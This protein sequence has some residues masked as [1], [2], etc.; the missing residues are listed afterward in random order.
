ME[1]ASNIT[2]EN[3]IV[4]S[5]NC[6]G[7]NQSHPFLDDICKA[8]NAKIIMVQE[9]WQTPSNMSKIL[10]Y[11]SK[12][13]GFGVSAMDTALS[14]SVLRGRTYGGV[15]TLVR[16]DYLSYTTCLK[17]A[18]RYT[19]VSIGQTIFINVYFPCSSSSSHE[20]VETLLI[21]INDVVT[22]FPDFEIVMGGDFNCVLSDNSKTSNVIRRFMMKLNLSLVTDLIRPNCDYTYYHESLHHYSFVDYFMFTSSLTTNAIEFKVLDDML[23][24]SD[25]CGIYLALSLSMKTVDPAAD[26]GPKSA[27]NATQR[28]NRYTLRWDHGSLAD[29]YSIC[30]DS[31]SPVLK[32]IDL[33]YEQCSK[34]VGTNDSYICGLDLGHLK[35][36]AIEKIESAYIKITK[37]LAV[38]ANATIPKTC[39]T[40]LKHWWNEELQSLK[41][42][43]MESNEAWVTAGKPKHGPL[44]DIRK[45]DKYAYK[46]AIRRSKNSQIDKVSDSLLSTFTN[47][48]SNSFWKIWK[49]KMGTHK[50]K[51]KLVDNKSEDSEIANSFASY[52]SKACSCNSEERSKE[53]YE[54]YCNTKSKRFNYENIANY[55]TNVEL[56]DASIHKLKCGKS[57]A[58]DNLTAEH[59]KNCH[60]IIVMILTKLFNLMIMF[61]YVPNDF[62]KSILIPIPKTDCVNASAN[63]E[64]Y[65]GISIAP[66]I[67]KVFEHCLLKLFSTYLQNSNVMQFGFKSKSGCNHALY[68]VRKT[69]EFFIERD[70]SVNLCALDMSKAF[71]KMNKH[72]LFVKLMNRNCP[73]V[74]I[75]IL[76]CWY[77]KNFASVKWGDSYSPFVQLQTGTR[78]GGITSP[79]LFA[80]FINDVIVKLQR[81]SLGCHIRN[82][83]FNVFMYAD[84]MLLASIS[85]NELQLMINIVRTELKWLDMEINVKKSMCMRMGKRF[86]CPTCELVLDNKPIKWVKEMRYLG[87]YFTAASSFKCNLHYAKVSFFRS[88]NSLLSKLGTHPSPGIVL[89]LVSSYCNSSL[90][91]G[92][93]S[94]HLSKANYNSISYPYNATYTK[95]FSTFDK[96]I[97]TLCQY[98]SGELPSS[99]LVDLR[100]LNFYARLNEGDSN[101]ASILF[102]W[103]G[104]QERDNLE[105]KY[106]LGAPITVNSYKIGIRNAFND[107]CLSLI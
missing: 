49:S 93:E 50:M 24:M 52:F 1:M 56:V 17:C 84:D 19:I 33:F 16:N 95:L 20:V 29:Y 89:Y 59:L 80:I 86:D 79:Y 8:G 15:A 14:C 94:L 48:D 2:L 37:I 40:T 34:V 99:Y 100:T 21:E 103:F 76:D 39:P 72:A 82:I 46:L 7:L 63:V 43:A 51:P 13:S 54:E 25:H 9:H 73:L 90:F 22:L 35:A 60:P 91:Y 31:L 18:E 57:A 96:N 78:Q 107:H 6:H 67:S 44:A 66:V 53:L 30:L 70:S 32:E 62:G 81:S 3:T 36:T 10:N 55:L 42:A 92:L 58:L 77:A 45:S 83:C 11:S 97:I 106:G 41:R 26:T 71:D 69:V 4:I 27:P 87:L 12:Y 65:R 61:E 102:Q 101:P 85:L 64:D 98:Y 105:I 23:N 74:L 75:N 88:L 28:H 104:Q 68:A 5:Y 38:S 47:R